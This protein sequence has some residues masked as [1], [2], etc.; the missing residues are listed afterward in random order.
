MI[1][2]LSLARYFGSLYSSKNNWNLKLQAATSAN[3]FFTNILL[4]ALCGCPSLKST[5][6]LNVVSDNVFDEKLFNITDS[7]HS[8]TFCSSMQKLKNFIH[9]CFS[10]K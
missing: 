4:T 5:T 6:R 2:S 8:V 3:L 10:H 1:S 7:V 9:C